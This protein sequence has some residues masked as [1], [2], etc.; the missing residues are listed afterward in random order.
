MN[1][2][3]ALHILGGSLAL[4]G[5]AV[6]AFA[7]KGSRVH[8][9]A[10]TVFALAMLAL[11]LT[12]AVLGP[13]DV[14]PDS[15]IGGLVVVYFVATGWATARRR[16]ASPGAFDIVAFLFI[17][18]VAI[19]TAVVAIGQLRAGIV[20]ESPPPPAVLLAFAGLC[21]LA[22]LGDLRWLLR[23]TLTPAQR[24]RRHLWRMGWAFFMA[25]GAF[26]LG[27]QDVM[28]EAWRGW[29]GWFALAFAPLG[30]VAWGLAKV[31]ARRP[32]IPP[33]HFS[34]V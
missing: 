25:T 8:G 5:G 32:V 18:F 22:A 20:P 15:P 19:A 6:A 9:M 4:A 10:G 3:L 14:P 21:T 30:L 28:P 11:G 2:I 16:E 7:R 26:F 13:Q 1:A 31:R 24:F 34:V 17:T 23:R 12:A 33:D 29:P 27:Q